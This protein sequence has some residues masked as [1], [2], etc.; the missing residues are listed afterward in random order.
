ME[1]KTTGGDTVSTELLSNYIKSLINKFFKILP[2]KENGEQSL[3]IYMQSLQSEILGC[4]DL[5]IAFNN[6]P[7]IISLVAILQNMID[8]P[9]CTVKA[10][11]REVFKA[12]SICNKL[13]FKYCSK[14]E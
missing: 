5:I 12:I 8:N 13:K 6:D 11:K 7:E 3:E 9:D 2:I 10:V 4:K 14:E 1:Y